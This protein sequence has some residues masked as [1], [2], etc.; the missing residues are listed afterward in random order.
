AHRLTR[1]KNLLLDGIAYRLMRRFPK[2]ASKII[3]SLVAKELP[4]DYDV[5]RHFNPPYD[6]W[7]QRLCVVLDGD[8]FAAISAGD[9]SIVTDRLREVTAT[10]IQLES[11]ATL[12]ADV[13]VT[14]TG[15]DLV[16]MGG[17]EFTV[18]GDPVDLGQTVAYKSMM[19]SGMPNFA[20]VFG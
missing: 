8:L 16:P 5:D 2:R 13:I 14:A 19:L 12:E 6:P 15:L 3:R 17:I 1:R 9:A 11:G 18:D 7:D 10:G 20:Y 4:P